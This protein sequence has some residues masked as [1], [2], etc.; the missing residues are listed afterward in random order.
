LK[1]E[2]IVDLDQLEALPRDAT[3]CKRSTTTLLIKNIPYT[4]Q[5]PELK[6]L[7]E[8]YGSCVKF[9]VSPF[10]TLAVVEY[11]KASQALAAIKNLAYY[12]VNYVT[13]IYLEFA[14]V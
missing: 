3:T 4:A 10:N 7:F 14:P 2:N 1:E 12:K 8:R 5:V 11:S 6:E 9:L 13:P